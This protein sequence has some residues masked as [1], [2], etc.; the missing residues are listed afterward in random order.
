VTSDV[1][2][3]HETYQAAKRPEASDHYGG[4]IENIS[5]RLITIAENLVYGHFDSSDPRKV[6]R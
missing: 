4:A 6:R 5:N 3:G 2:N 1:N